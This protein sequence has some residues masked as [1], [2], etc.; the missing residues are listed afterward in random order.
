MK[1]MM[2][3]LIVVSGLALAGCSGL[4]DGQNTGKPNSGV[5]PADVVRDGD[6]HLVNDTERLPMTGQWCHELDHNLQR[7]GSPS[8]CVA[9]Y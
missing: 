7:I 2:V 4:G 9:P 1:K 8:N 6:G 5:T 3:A